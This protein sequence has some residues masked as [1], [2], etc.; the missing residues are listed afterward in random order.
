MNLQELVGQHLI[1][2]LSGLSLTEDEKQFILVNNIGGVILF[3][4]NVQSPADAVA[5][6]DAPAHAGVDQKQ[7]A[8]AL[9]KVLLLTVFL[10]RELHGV[11]LMTLNKVLHAQSGHI[12]G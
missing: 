10:I 11:V 3:A 4:R 6:L 9:K 2:G 7:E 5:V 1:I 12:F 8:V